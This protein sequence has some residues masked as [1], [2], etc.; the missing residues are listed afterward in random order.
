MISLGTAFFRI[1]THD[2]VRNSLFQHL[3][4]C[5]RSKQLFF[6][7]VHM[8][9][10]KT[11]FFNI[12]AFTTPNYFYSYRI[13]EKVHMD[14]R[15]EPN[16]FLRVSVLS[17]IM[18]VSIPNDSKCCAGNVCAALKSFAM[19]GRTPSSLANLIMVAPFR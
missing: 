1:C 3:C 5:F 15:S 12:F 7:S 9:S 19:R 14:L 4:F 11:A 10:F 17:Y 16:T 13:L 8:I 18:L 2:F 6:V